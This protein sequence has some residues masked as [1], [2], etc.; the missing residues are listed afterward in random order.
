MAVQ[1]HFWDTHLAQ[2]SGGASVVQEVCTALLSA[3]PI[4][5]SPGTRWVIL[6]ANSLQQ[7]RH[8]LCVL[9]VLLH[10]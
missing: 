9:T 4:Q 1:T 5:L 3:Q 2:G 10:H 6:A 8:V 7:W